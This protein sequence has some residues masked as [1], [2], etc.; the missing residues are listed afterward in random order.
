MS[1]RK[2]TIFGSTGQLGTDLVEILGEKSEYEII[3]L[4]HEDADC[5]DLAAVRNVLFK[6]RPDVVINCAAYVRVDD[7]EDCP[8]DA[9]RINAVGAFHVARASAELG[10]SC[11]YISTDYVFDG[12]KDGP[13]LESDA[14][15]PI[16]VYGTSKLAGEYLVRQAAA[17][18]LIV[19][20]AGLFGK[21]GARG[22]GGN[23][24]EAVLKKANSGEPLKVVNDIRLSPT[25]TRDAAIGLAVLL[26]AGA[27]GIVHLTNQDDCSWYEFAAEALRLTGHHANLA[28]ISRQEYR[29]RAQRPA[30]STLL[31]SRPVVKLRPWREALKDYL[32]HRTPTV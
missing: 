1:R 30:N 9:F 25:Y 18:H 24:V 15:N 31:A 14:P 3:A 23:F 29:S 26:Q 6:S 32:T 28:A 12:G 27:E 19:R 7:C 16:N 21:A 5:A 2:I 13:Y 20:V 4:Q 8:E 22:K 17:R 10:A 11:V